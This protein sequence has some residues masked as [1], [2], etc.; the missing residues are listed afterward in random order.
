MSTTATAED[1]VAALR[2]NVDAFM[3][4]TI[5]PEAFGERQ[6][7]LWAEITA[8]GLNHE[9]LAILRAPK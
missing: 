1:L 3:A 8:A 4:F 7:V 5:E 9:V 2:Q 6:R